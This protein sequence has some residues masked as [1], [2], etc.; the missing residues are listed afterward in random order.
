MP[1]DVNPEE[2]E[3]IVPEP[4]P[5]EVEPKEVYITAPGEKE[6]PPAPDKG[7]EEKLTKLEARL[8]ALELEKTHWTNKANKEYRKRSDLEREIAAL[9]TSPVRTHVPAETEPNRAELD[10]LV[11]DGQWDKAVEKLA[12]KK[13]DERLTA[14]QAKNQQDRVQADRT[15]AFQQAQSE[16]VYKYPD[17]ANDDSELTEFYLKVLDKF[18]QYR[19]NPD[20]PM[21][22]MYRMEEEAKRLGVQLTPSEEWSSAYKGTPAVGGN[23]EVARR[24]RA[25][26]GSI[27]AG[28]GAAG[29]RTYTLSKEQ[30]EIVRNSGIDEKSYARVAS[31]LEGNGNGGVEA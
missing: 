16:A 30:Q 8:E 31:Q 27:G 29:S 15:I 5:A 13:V 17:L 26:A 24:A 21:L 20:G 18:P 14:I 28:R 11:E 7:A 10:K 12:E 25:Q 4:P 9:R 1:D 3:V 2:K 6:T 23:K 22:T 19:N